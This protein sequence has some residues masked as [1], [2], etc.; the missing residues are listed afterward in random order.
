MGQNDH[1]L[2]LAELEKVYGSLK[3]VKELLTSRKND[4]GVIKYYLENTLLEITHL[5][6]KWPDK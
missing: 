5:L 4:L 1:T 3:I 2:A 6:D